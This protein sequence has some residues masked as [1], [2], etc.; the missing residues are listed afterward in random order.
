VGE[1]PAHLTKKRRP[2]RL[3]TH[4]TFSADRR[5][6]ALDVQ[7]GLD[8]YLGELPLDGSPFRLW[9]QFDRCFNHAQFSPTDP[10]LLLTAQ[11]NWHDPRTGE[12]GELD[13]RIWLIRRGETARP[14]FPEAPSRMRGHEWWGADGRHVWYVDYDHGTEKINIETGERTLVWPGGTWHS[15][16]SRNGRY[17]VGDRWRDG[18]MQVV[19]FDAGTGREV[20]IVTAMPPTPVPMASYHLH[21]HP[22]F[23]ADDRFV[24]YTTMA[25]GGVDV[26]VVAVEDL[27]VAAR[28]VVS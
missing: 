24:C 27:M 11:D 25:R 14:L 6:L 3:A 21:P 22:Q 1:F 2:H 23:C 10:D 8:W 9:Q 17:L 5:A 20:N 4:L 15:H 18:I 28:K 16:V 19:F 26:A 12:T 13:D 7:I